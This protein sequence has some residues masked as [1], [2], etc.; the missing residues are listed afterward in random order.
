M[1]ADGAFFVRLLLMPE[2]TSVDM[3]YSGVNLVV[4]ANRQYRKWARM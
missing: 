2:I 4:Y 1:M 3:L